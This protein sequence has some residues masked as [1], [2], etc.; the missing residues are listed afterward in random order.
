[1]DQKQSSPEI[2]RLDKKEPNADQNTL[3]KPNQGSKRS[4]ATASHTDSS[5]SKKIRLIEHKYALME[6]NKEN[7][8]EV[9]KASQRGS[10]QR[11]LPSKCIKIAKKLP[12]MQK[13]Q[14][15]KT[16]KKSTKT[17]ILRPLKAPIMLSIA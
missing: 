8:L 7:Y 4:L 6:I 2:N 1:M 11:N 14:N 16:S 17:H 12:K 5:D 9:R 3:E 13:T 15:S 10:I